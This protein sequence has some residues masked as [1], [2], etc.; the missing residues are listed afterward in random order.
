MDKYKHE[1]DQGLRITATSYYRMEDVLIRKH[2]TKTLSR[3]DPH[4]QGSLSG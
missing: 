3:S 4:I 2:W 1:C